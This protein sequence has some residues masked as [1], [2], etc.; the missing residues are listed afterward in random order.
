MIFGLESLI[1]LLL[2]HFQS[3]ISD[4]PSTATTTCLFHQ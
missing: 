4:H 2:F 1:V 3:L